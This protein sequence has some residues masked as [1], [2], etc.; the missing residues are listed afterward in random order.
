MAAGQINL[1]W[2]DVGEWEEV[3]KPTSPF[4][5][6]TSSHG[7]IVPPT[8]EAAGPYQPKLSPYEL[9]KSAK[10]LTDL[11]VGPARPGQPNFPKPESAWKDV[12]PTA[13]ESVIDTLN[14]PIEAEQ[15]LERQAGKKFYGKDKPIMELLGQDASEYYGKKLTKHPVI[16]ALPGF[17]ASELGPQA[18][19]IFSGKW[20]TGAWQKANQASKFDAELSQLYQR[21]AAEAQSWFEHMPSMNPET[22]KFPL[23][24]EIQ[25][26]PTSA[27]D[28]QRLAAYAK[29]PAVVRGAASNPRIDQAVSDLPPKAPRNSALYRE[30]IKQTI[31]A[32]EPFEPISFEE[33][34]WHPTSKAREVL[35]G[36]GPIGEKVNTLISQ[37]VDQPANWLWNQAVKTAERIPGLRTFASQ[38][39]EKLTLERGRLLDGLTQQAQ[40]EFL[41]PL[42]VITAEQRTGLGEALHNLREVAPA[43]VGHVEK[44]DTLVGKLTKNYVDL[45]DKWVAEGL[46]DAKKIPRETMLENIGNYARTSYLRPPVVPG[47]A[48]SV[49]SGGGRLEGKFLKQIHRKMTDLEWGESFLKVSGN[50]ADE[51]AKMSKAELAE[52]GVQAKK[53]FGWI[54]EGDVVMYETLKS[55]INQSVGA[56]WLDAIAHQP[57]LFSKSQT[58]NLIP[59]RSFAGDSI[60]LGPL[61]DGYVHP[62][63]VDELK[64]FLSP[65]Y[66]APGLG[67]EMLSWWKAS[68]VVGN[69]ATVMRNMVSGAT[70]QSDMAGVP[71]WKHLIKWKDSQRGFWTKSKAY[72]KWRDRGL[73]GSDF[74]RV[75]VNKDAFERIVGASKTP[76]EFWAKMLETSGR[77]REKLTGWY[78]MIDHSNRMYLAE[79]AETMGA[80]PAQAVHFANKWQLDYRYVP[81]FLEALRSGPGGAFFPFASFYTLMTPRILETAV[82]RPWVLLKYPA[83]VA[84]ANALSEHLMGISHE[85]AERN[86]PEFLRNMPYTMI[87][88]GDKKRYLSLD[89]LL[90]FGGVKTAFLNVEQGLS[91]V[92]GLGPMGA[93]NVAL[94][95]YDPFTERY[96]YHKNDLPSVKR[97]KIGAYLLRMGMPGVITHALNIYDAVQ[98]GET[99]TGFPTTPG[100]RTARMFGLSIYEGGERSRQWSMKKLIREMEELNRS[101]KYALKDARTQEEKTRLT[102]ERNQEAERLNKQIQAMSR[103]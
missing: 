62:G 15:W 96:L 50:S 46:I 66:N 17:I 11:Q 3:A 47:E 14:L 20:L 53:D 103:R 7:T 30:N 24:E 51:I 67:S 44:F 72:E 49:L 25:H 78:G 48:P 38:D 42:G 73:F 10:E 23:A 19:A 35:K 61:V 77:T 69:P 86:K 82:K 64:H 43:L 93:I 95:G 40:E 87:L 6:A 63:L 71:V 102:Q 5:L 55:T 29:T 8:R 79:M 88:P 4:Q 85:E 37:Y 54:T 33:L 59:V 94:N 83:A 52:I 68:K 75:E 39:I 57:G 84:G 9:G 58:G 99:R 90:P 41:K 70:V 1:E 74:E 92:K 100:L 28:A 18:A 36:S 34:D 101:W 81:K 60:R 26:L 56:R 76:D 22:M 27:R 97:A 13:I 80:T 12:V 32:S 2:E 16:A 65:E 98:R 31:N 21:D 91:M 89:Y 45:Y